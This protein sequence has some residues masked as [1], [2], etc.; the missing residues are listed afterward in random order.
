MENEFDFDDDV[1]PEVTRRPMLSSWRVQDHTGFI[2]DLTEVK[3][4]VY[5]IEEKGGR[6]VHQK[7]YWE[8]S[9]GFKSADNS[10]VQLHLNHAWYR[11][12]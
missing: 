8:C 10:T 1:I 7:L 12:G 2:H 11:E 3:K 9:C 4:T 6:S 5:K